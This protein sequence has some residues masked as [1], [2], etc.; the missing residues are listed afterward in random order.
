[1]T[2]SICNL[3]RDLA[4]EILSRVPV[5]SL[6]AV[7]FTCKRWNTL[8]KDVSFIKKY[9]GQAKEE[10]AKKKEFMVIK[11]MDFRVYLLHV[12]LHNDDKSFIRCEAK[13]TSQDDSDQVDLYRVF[14]SDGLLLSI[15]KDCTKLVAWNPYSRN[16]RWIEFESSPDLMDVYMYAFGYEKSNNSCHNYKILRFV[17]DYCGFEC[18]IYDF[19]S[20][21][22]RVLDITPYEEIYID[23]HRRGGVSLKG[24]TYLL[25]QSVL[26]SH[27]DLVCFDFTRKKF[28]LPLS[29]PF[30][31]S[32]LPSALTLSSVREEQLP[33]M[34]LR[35]DTFTMEIWITTRIEPSAVSWNS[36]VFLAVNLIQLTFYYFCFEGTSFF[37]DEEKN[38][39]V[40][41]DNKNV[42]YIFGVDGTLKKEHFGLSKK[43]CYTHACSYV[44][45]LVQL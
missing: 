22:W 33:V 2:S 39:A 9:V 21:S 36:K 3:P 4:E 8:S 12:T 32:N 16:S 5:K 13:F 38:F 29:L 23:Y 17:E 41:F 44:P 45:S 35:F 34:L 24:N 30:E 26:S 25:C 31:Y 6:K 15:S 11:P 27:V 10:A 7:R 19:N 14:H 37:I 42:A 43:L 18:K 20:D 28:W 40:V 1:M